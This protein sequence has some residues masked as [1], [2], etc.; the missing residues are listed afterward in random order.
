MSPLQQQ[1]TLAFLP[2]RLRTLTTPWRDQQVSVGN[3]VRTEANQ[4]ILN[5]D[6][7]APD[8]V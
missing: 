8:P 5:S 7:P 3:G 4:I 1:L 2:Q 6:T